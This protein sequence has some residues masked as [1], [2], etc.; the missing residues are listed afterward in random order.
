M[1]IGA[2]FA[3]S[4]VLFYVFNKLG[5]MSAKLGFVLKRI[6]DL[7][8]LDNISHYSRV[9]KTGIGI[10]D[11]AIFHHLIGIGIFKS[12]RT[13]YDSLVG[14]LFS[15]VGL[16][17]F[18]IFIYLLFKLI[19]N[20]R[21]YCDENTKRYNYLFMVVLVCYIV[22]N[23]IT[24]FFLISR[25]VFPVVLYLSIL[26][27]YQKLEYGEFTYNKRSKSESLNHNSSLEQ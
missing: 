18:L 6:V 21:D 14:I 16:I 13:W 20:N 19:Q 25:S 5:M 1:Y 8:F 3:A 11:T 10:E 2:G 12:S 24:E 27:H 26:Y 9:V 23:F 17:G 4:L 15:H 7:S 22:A